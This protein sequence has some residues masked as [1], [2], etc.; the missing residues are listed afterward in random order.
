MEI[1]EKKREIKKKT[2]T[3]MKMPLMDLL[4]EWT[5]LREK[6]HWARGYF[7]RTL[8]NWKIKTRTVKNKHLRAVGKL[9][10][11]IMNRS[12]GKEINNKYLKQ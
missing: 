8:Q 11:H 6:N 3:G 9:Q 5:W 12:E 7:N 2:E 1:L 4:V 10:V